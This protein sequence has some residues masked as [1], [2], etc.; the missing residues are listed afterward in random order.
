MYGNVVN[1]IN[2]YMTNDIP[3]GIHVACNSLGARSLPPLIK[4]STNNVI[5]VTFNYMKSLIPNITSDMEAKLKTK[6]TEAYANVFNIC[7]HILTALLGERYGEN[8]CTWTMLS[9]KEKDEI[10][11]VFERIAFY[12][13]KRSGV[14]IGTPVEQY[15]GDLVSIIDTDNPMMP[16]HLA[17]NNWMAVSLIQP[18]LRNA[19]RVSK[20]FVIVIPKY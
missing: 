5:Q 6:A 20:L 17:E 10:V 13:N 1:A 12:W 7:K 15:N 2:Y 3:K 14:N 18:L 8:G 19:R 11:Y 9:K 16:L 4:Y